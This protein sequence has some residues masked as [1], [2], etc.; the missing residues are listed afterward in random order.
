MASRCLHRQREYRML[1]SRSDGE[2]VSHGGRRRDHQAEAKAVLA[3]HRQLEAAAEEP[4]APEDHLGR[5]VR[6]LRPFVDQVLPP[7]EPPRVTEAKR[8]LGIEDQ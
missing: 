2:G 4:L 1:V 8:V 5:L 7:K 6:A 3:A